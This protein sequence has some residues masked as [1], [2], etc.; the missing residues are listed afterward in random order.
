MKKM[1]LVLMMLVSVGA[2]TTSLMIP[3]SVVLDFKSFGAGIS[4][5]HLVASR[6]EIGKALSR[7]NITF[8][9]QMGYGMEGETKLCVEG[10]WDALLKLNEVV[11]KVPV[12]ASVPAPKLQFHA[13]S[14]ED[15]MKPTEDGPVAPR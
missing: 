6:R 13:G 4:Q 3:R 11:E 9:Q 15:A 10:Y 7:G 8:F 2:S 12:T 1:L 5:P 14:C